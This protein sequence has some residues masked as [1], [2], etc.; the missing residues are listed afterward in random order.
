ML[1]TADVVSEGAA[2]TRAPLWHGAGFT[3]SGVKVA[4]L[5]PGFQGYQAL[6]GTEL[7]ALH[8]EPQSL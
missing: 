6:L 2:V 7:P 1:F 5:D 8:E 4:I 3:G